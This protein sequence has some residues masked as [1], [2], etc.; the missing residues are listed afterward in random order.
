MQL[1]LNKMRFFYLYCYGKI[2]HMQTNQIMAPK[3]FFIFSPGC[4]SAITKEHKSLQ[5][6]AIRVTCLWVTKQLYHQNITPTAIFTDQELALQPRTS[7][8]YSSWKPNAKQMLRFHLTI[9]EQ[10]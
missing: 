7:P 6:A 8:V 9:L 4:A 3:L 2:S 1:K 5:Y 10:I